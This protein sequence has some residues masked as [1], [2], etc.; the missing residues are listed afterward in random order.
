[1]AGETTSTIGFNVLIVNPGIHVSTKWAFDEIDRLR[2]KL[3][4]RSSK[5]EISN[6]QKR[7]TSSSI[8]SKENLE[9][10]ENDFEQVVFKKYPQIKAIK[11]KLIEQGALFASMSGSGSSVYGIFGKVPGELKKYFKGK[12]YRVFLE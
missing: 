5:L 9:F 7:I 10:P 11:D 12:G 3:E 4:V 1:M 6:F 2:E 8:K